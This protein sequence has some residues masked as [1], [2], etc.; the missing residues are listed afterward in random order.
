MRDG[1]GGGD[2]RPRRSASATRARRLAPASARRGPAAQRRSAFGV[3]PAGRH[4]KRGRYT[5]IPDVA[6]HRDAAD[7]R[8]EVQDHEHSPCL[9]GRRG[10]SG[11]GSHSVGRATPAYVRD[12]FRASRSSTMSS[13]ASGP[14][15][16]TGLAAIHLATRTKVPRGTTVERVSTTDVRRESGPYPALEILCRCKYSVNR[17]TKKLSRAE[18]SASRV[19]SANLGPDHRP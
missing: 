10:D 3:S 16:A 4:P 19:R 6:G 12:R 13:T 2:G 18:R 8:E 14:T 9:P 17:P 15:E 1:R 11:R 7:G 5:H